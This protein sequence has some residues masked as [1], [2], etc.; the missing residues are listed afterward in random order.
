M[1]ITLTPQQAQRLLAAAAYAETNNMPG[2]DLDGWTLA[3]WG[4]LDRACVQLRQGLRAHGA[5]NYRQGPDAEDMERERVARDADSEV[6][7][8]GDDR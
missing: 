3:G 4:T 6:E 7:R 2:G 8:R 1:R 5:V